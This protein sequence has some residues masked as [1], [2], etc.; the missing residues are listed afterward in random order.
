MKIL[1][2]KQSYYSALI[3]HVEEQFEVYLDDVLFASCNTHFEA[4]NFARGLRSGISY[5]GKSV[6]LADLS[7]ETELKL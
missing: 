3:S 2:K 4:I 1:V 7:G 6:F 5:S